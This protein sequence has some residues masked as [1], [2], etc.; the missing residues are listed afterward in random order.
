MHEAIL[1]IG[2]RERENGSIVLDHLRTKRDPSGGSYLQDKTD[3]LTSPFTAGEEKMEQ[4][5]F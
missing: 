2:E 4:L 5:D 1:K 3:P